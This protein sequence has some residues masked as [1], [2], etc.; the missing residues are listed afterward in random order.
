MAGD[1]SSGPLASSPRAPTRPRRIRRRIG[2]VLLG[3][4]FAV[5]GWFIVSGPR[6]W[7][8]RLEPW[9]SWTWELPGPLLY[10]VILLYPAAVLVFLPEIFDALRRGRALPVLMGLG[11]GGLL[12]LAGMMS[13]AVI[14]RYSSKGLRIVQ[15]EDPG[16]YER[17][18]IQ[19]SGCK[20]SLYV[21]LWLVP[22]GGDEFELIASGC[23]CDWP[24]EVRQS[25]HG[26]RYLI[27]DAGLRAGTL[28][29]LS[30][31]TPIV[32]EKPDIEELRSEFGEDIT[33]IA[34]RD[35]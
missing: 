27:V 2:L 5:P 11:V 31:E 6:V 7:N 16:V 8:L 32:R 30:T 10:V 3:L 35:G 28:V 19:A 24:F 25:P 18:V 20:E 17:A 4:C 13:A 34:T 26:P 21:F 29:D 33:A 15:L 14:I 22:G 9:L 23:W 1:S 12:C